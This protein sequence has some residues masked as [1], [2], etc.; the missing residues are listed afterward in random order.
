VRG[1]S[2]RAIHPRLSAPLVAVLEA[3]GVVGLDDDD[4]V[5]LT[6]PEKLE[7]LREAVASRVEAL[8]SER[9]KFLLVAARYSPTCPECDHETADHRPGRG[10]ECGLCSCGHGGHE[11]GLS[12]CGRRA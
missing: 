1:R 2:R 9:D 8:R 6:Y 12:R 11:N 4:E 3:V 5:R 10:W 7:I